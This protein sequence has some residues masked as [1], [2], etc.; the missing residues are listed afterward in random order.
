[1]CGRPPSP[2]LLL[3]F[4]RHIFIST[5][6]GVVPCGGRKDS[7]FIIIVQIILSGP[8]ESFNSFRIILKIEFCLSRC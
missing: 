1:M 2:L 4:V 6:A 8:L 5:T 3:C 7:L